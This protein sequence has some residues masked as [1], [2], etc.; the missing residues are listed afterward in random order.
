MSSAKAEEERKKDDLDSFRRLFIIL[1]TLNFFFFFFVDMEYS[2]TC[3][4][5]KERNPRFFQR[6]INLAEGVAV[7]SVKLTDRQILPHPSPCSCYEEQQTVH[8]TSTEANT[9]K[10]HVRNK[11]VT[12]IKQLLLKTKYKRS[13]LH[14]FQ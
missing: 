3:Q 2:G 13:L 12:P 5:S 4:N 8:G 14:F 11:A 1:Y 6:S 10:L 7:Y 9:V